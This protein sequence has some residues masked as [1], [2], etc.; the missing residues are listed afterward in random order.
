MLKI[1]TKLCLFLVGTL[2]PTQA[3]VPKKTATPEFTNTSSTRAATPLA[4]ELPHHGIIQSKSEAIAYFQHD[5]ASSQLK[6]EL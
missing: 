6:V 4:E 2:A 1:I 5:M 3:D